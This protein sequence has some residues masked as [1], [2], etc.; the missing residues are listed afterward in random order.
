MFGPKSELR[1]TAALLS[2]ALAVTGTAALSQPAN[3]S[4]QSLNSSVSF[5]ASKFV[6]GKAL[7][8]LSPGTPDYGFT[9]EAILQRRAAG[10]R[11]KAVGT[12]DASQ[13]LATTVKA[14]LADTTV[15]SKSAVFGYA[16]DSNKSLK[17]GL[18]GKFLFTSIAVGVPNAPLRNAIVSDFKKAIAKDGALANSNGNAFDYAWA[19]LGLSAVGQPKLADIV[20]VKLCT[21][22]R[23]D[24]GFG[25]DQTGSTT[26]SS[27]D[28]SGLA[29]QSLALAKRTGTKAQLAIYAKAIQADFTY[30]KGT[31][32]AGNHWE[33]FGDYDVNGTAY[34][35]M[36]LKANG[37]GITAVQSWLKS[38][39]ATTGGFV[40]PWSNGLGD[41]YATAQAIVPALGLSYLNLLPTS[42]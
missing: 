14:V 36:G 17:P 32:V 28:S 12:T 16:Y 1:F 3:A 25:L 19:V 40:T 7:D 9:L 41:V 13:D 35:A 5:L 42:K 20:A 10:Q 26:T 29:L 23:A 30:L 18:A 2:A 8:G 4:D 33:S 34:A 31:E 11:L 39:L 22:Q 37:N 21:L 24:G 15:A 38:K 6:G 27:A